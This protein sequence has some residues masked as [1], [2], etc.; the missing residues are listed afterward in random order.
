M[1]HLAHKAYLLLGGADMATRVA[2]LKEVIH[3]DHLTSD[4]HLCFQKV[5]YM[6]ADGRVENGYRFIWRRD[7][8][9]LQA[10]RGQA[11]IPFLKDAETLIALARKDNWDE[12]DD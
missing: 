11:R 8:G 12:D 7:D 4:W 2:V 9:S 6:H 5:R 3:P 10:A 1:A